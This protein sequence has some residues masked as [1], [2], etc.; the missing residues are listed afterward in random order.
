MVNFDRCCQINAERE[1][2]DSFIAHKGK[3]FKLNKY[4]Y[5]WSKN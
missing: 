1:K 5:K 3:K 4:K 2:E